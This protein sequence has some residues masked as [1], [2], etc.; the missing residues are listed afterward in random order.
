MKK[1]I[2][3]LTIFTVSIFLSVLGWF[4]YGRFVYITSVE[5]DLSIAEYDKKYFANY[6]IW[7]RSIDKVNLATVIILILAIL[8]IIISGYLN[9][10][11]KIIAYI[12]LILD[13]IVTGMVFFA[14]M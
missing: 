12:I 7:L 10:K 6:P 13:G 3:S 14:Y 11:S 9:R 2:V 8:L 4:N 5:P 1:Q